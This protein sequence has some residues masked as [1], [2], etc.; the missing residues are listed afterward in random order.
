MG[1]TSPQLHIKRMV[2]LCRKL[3]T[4]YDAGIPMLQA[5]GL[6]QRDLKDPKTRDLLTRMQD[7]I[8]QGA[9]LEEAARSESRYLPTYVV[10]AIAAGEHG[11]RLDVMFNDLADY[12]EDRLTM[13][14]EIVGALVYPVILMLLAWFMGTFAIMLIKDVITSAFHRGGGSYDFLAFGGSYLKLQGITLALA[15]IAAVCLIFLARIGVWRW[16][17][18]FFSTH[19]WP[20]SP[21]TRRFALARFFRS[22]SLLIGGGVAIDRCIE[23]SATVASNPYIERE[24][25]KAVRPVKE[26]YTLTEAFSPLR[27]LTPTAREMITVGEESGKLEAQ[28][29]KVS[30][31]YSQEAVH[32]AQI[33]TKVLYFAIYMGAALAVGYV[34]ITFYTTLYGTMFD[35]LGV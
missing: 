6:V 2:P 4:A 22:M 10:E 7:K 9:T 25:L 31:W 33:A 24:L 12:F 17:W 14:R 21:I 1:L 19:F 34:I 11:G 28:L 13:R 27:Y 20:L 32:A 35:E 15:A 30:Q 23:R 3:A 5:L 26:G 16:I 29:R 8:R 18:G